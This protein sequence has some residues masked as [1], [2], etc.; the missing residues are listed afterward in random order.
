MLWYRS[1]AAILWYYRGRVLPGKYNES[2]LQKVA[3]N[4][5]L[6][7]LFLQVWMK[8]I[9]FNLEEHTRS[10]CLV[11]VLLLASME[12]GFVIILDKH[13]KGSS[14]VLFSLQI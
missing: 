1:Y 6:V 2:P 9:F 7:L 4:V 13:I 10:S 11:L 5:A 14:I 12:E 3:G 8:V